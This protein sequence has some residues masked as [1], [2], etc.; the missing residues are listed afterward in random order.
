MLLNDDYT[1]MEFVTGILERYFVRSRQEAHLIMMQVHNEGSAICGIYTRDVA[2]TKALQVVC[3]AREYG[4]PL[5][6]EAVKDW[7][8]K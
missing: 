5:I 6:C 2:Q 7:Y 1:P 8:C 3:Y 4:H